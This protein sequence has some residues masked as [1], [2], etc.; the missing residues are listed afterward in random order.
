M[1]KVTIA[2]DLIWQ[3][4]TIAKKM[5][6]DEAIE[7]AKNLRIGGYDDWRLPTIEELSEVVTICE[8]IAVKF[9]SDMQDNEK[10]NITNQRYLAN[11]RKLGFGSYFYWSSTTLAGRFSY[12]WLVSFYNGLK[13]YNG[14]SNSLYVRCVRTG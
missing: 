12:A 3:K 5:N 9:G 8:G 10:K 1:S 11:Y 6:W 7:Y 4:C 14:K 2:G 13:Y